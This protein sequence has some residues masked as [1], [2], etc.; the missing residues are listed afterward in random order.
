MMVHQQ[1]LLQGDTCGVA[2]EQSVSACLEDVVRGS[3][4]ML[5]VICV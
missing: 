4:M 2:A 5:V 3:Q 1:Y